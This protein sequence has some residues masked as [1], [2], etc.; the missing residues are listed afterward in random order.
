MILKKNIKPIRN[1]LGLLSKI[2][3]V[4]FEWR[5]NRAEKGFQ[6]GL[7]ADEVE[8]VLPSAVV[9]HNDVKRIQE[10]ELGGVYV[11]A[12]NELHEM[13]KRLDARVKKLEKELAK[14]R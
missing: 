10:Q 14:K 11:A 7:I 1:G 6:T 12:I 3:G 13:V 9:E 5:D 8:K 4:T 2:E